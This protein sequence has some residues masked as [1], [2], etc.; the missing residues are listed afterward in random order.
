MNYSAIRDSQHDFFAEKAT[1]FFRN[2]SIT[3]WICY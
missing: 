1:A 2:L 3:S